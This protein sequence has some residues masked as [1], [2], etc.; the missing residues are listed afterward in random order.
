MVKA[1]V[2]CCVGHSLNGE[3][4]SAKS[5]P[6]GSFTGICFVWF[7]FSKAAEDVSELGAEEQQREPPQPWGAF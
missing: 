3:F 2:L 1:G 4:S 6:N 7:W 5:H